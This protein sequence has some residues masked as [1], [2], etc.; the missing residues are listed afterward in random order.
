MW[1]LIYF[2]P[3]WIVL[4]AVR[5]LFIAAGY[6]TV[7]LALLC[8]A[9][10]VR[11]NS[12]I[13][14]NNGQDIYVFSWAWMRP[15]N[16]FTDGIYCT[17]YFDYGFFW[18]CFVWCV[19]RNPANGLRTIKPFYARIAPLDVRFVGSLDRDT[20]ALTAYDRDDIEFW[21][22]CWQG[23]HAN[24]RWNFRLGARLYR[25]WIGIKIYPADIYGIYGVRAK[26]G[27]GFATQLKRLK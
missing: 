21:Y 5:T 26:H 19:I 15:W 27:A 1:R 12:D 9:Y 18:T 25:F 7:P 23:L 11:P 16:N 17:T 3:I 6:V 8:R 20:W 2:I 4:V 13:S 14:Y 10:E 24:F 22:L